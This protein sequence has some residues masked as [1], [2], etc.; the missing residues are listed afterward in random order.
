MWL[1]FTLILGVELGCH[2]S[3]DERL[4]VPDFTFRMSF[5]PWM[6]DFSFQI[7]PWN[8]VHTLDERLFVPDFTLEYR[9]YP[10]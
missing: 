5:I 8:I 3:L 4:F 2:S 10:G 6:N 9:S 7:L 1:I